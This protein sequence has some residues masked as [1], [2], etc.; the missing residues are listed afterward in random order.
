M[1]VPIRTDLGRFEPASKLLPLSRSEVQEHHL[2]SK[3][4]TPALRASGE[5]W[6]YN[7]LFR[8]QWVIWGVE[9]DRFRFQP[10][11]LGSFALYYQGGVWKRRFHY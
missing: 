9:S 5:E 1:R 2:G 6:V 8:W 4:V 11:H 10:D 7:Y 3:D